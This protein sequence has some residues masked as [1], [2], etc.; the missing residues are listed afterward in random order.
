MTEND[1]WHE[2]ELSPADS[3]KFANFIPLLT[4]FLPEQFVTNILNSDFHSY[5][6]K[7][8][9]LFLF[10]P[11]YM[12]A[13][14]AVWEY[15][16]NWGCRNLKGRDLVE[17]L[18]ALTEVSE[19][20]ITSLKSNPSFLNSI[21]T[22]HDA[23]SFMMEM[24]T[25]SFPELSEESLKNTFVRDV[26]KDDQMTLTMASN[27]I[28]NSWGPLRNKYKEIPWILDEEPLIAWARTKYDLQQEVPDSWVR[29][30]M[31]AT[32]VFA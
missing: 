26:I 9:V 20:N 2:I 32:D 19:E 15:P 17:F 24:R 25:F 30:F 4:M 12:E 8:K 1:Y 28:N 11:R 14:I 29:K 27:L 31:A 21:D 7:R 10:E 18:I 5:D 16:S 3:V 22:E 6:F 23:F 13:P